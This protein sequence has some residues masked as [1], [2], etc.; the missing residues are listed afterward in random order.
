MKIKRTRSYGNNITVH[1]SEYFSML[2]ISYT[3]KFLIMVVIF[4]GYLLR[5]V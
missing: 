1:F 5:N 4:H 2:P 3:A